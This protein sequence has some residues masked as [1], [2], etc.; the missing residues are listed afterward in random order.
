MIDITNGDF[1]TSDFDVDNNEIEL[2]LLDVSFGNVD[3]IIVTVHDSHGGSDL[4][5]AN[6]KADSFR[7]WYVV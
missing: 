2:D 5:D 4:N 1:T 7:D 6:T 3:T